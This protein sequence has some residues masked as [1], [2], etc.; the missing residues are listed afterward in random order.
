MRQCTRGPGIDKAHWLTRP[1]ARQM[2]PI[3]K[4]RQIAAPDLPS[5]RR[6]ERAQARSST[7]EIPCP[8]P[9]H[10]VERE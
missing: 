3:E 1:K 8:T 10:M 2:N 4:A 5:I 7:T 6:V 9:M